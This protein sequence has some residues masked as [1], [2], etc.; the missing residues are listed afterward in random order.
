[1]SAEEVATL[2]SMEDYHG[3]SKSWLPDHFLKPILDPYGFLPHEV[4]VEIVSV[5]RDLRDEVHHHEEA[6]AIV[7]ILGKKQHLPNP[8]GASAFLEN[9]STFT[10]CVVFMGN[11]EWFSLNASYRIDIPAGYKH[12]FTVEPE[13]VLYFLSAQSP[14]ITGPEGRNDYHK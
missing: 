6:D 12:G 7:N 9:S 2:I 10:P 3:F 1:M 5:T 8:V 11:N 14:P 13:G 4:Q